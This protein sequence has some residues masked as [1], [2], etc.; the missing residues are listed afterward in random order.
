MTEEQQLALALQMSMV[1]GS[2]EGEGEK[3]EEVVGMDTTPNPPVSTR[4]RE[5]GGGG[6]CGYGHH[7]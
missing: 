3:A 7:S 5:G 6:G 4:V 2:M 1:G